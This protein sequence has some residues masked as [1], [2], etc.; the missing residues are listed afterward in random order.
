MP[1][2]RFSI[3]WPDGAAE[4]C[5]SPSTVIRN[6]FTPGTTYPLPDF[7]AR[8]RAALTAASNRV[9]Q[10]HGSPCSLALGQLAR[11]ETTAAR[12]APTD[13]VKFISFKE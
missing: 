6:H 1:E 3:T 8:S 5:Y 7:L 13:H 10:I 12:Y 4:T 2:L 9:R 11:I